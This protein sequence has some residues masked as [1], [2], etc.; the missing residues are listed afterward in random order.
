[1]IETWTEKNTENAYKIWAPTADMPAGL[2]KVT[3]EMED[4]T[5]LRIKAKDRYMTV[6]KP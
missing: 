4:E 5:G 1:V 6:V 2:Y 3:C